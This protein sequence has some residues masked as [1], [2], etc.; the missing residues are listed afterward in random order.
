[1]QDKEK[2]PKTKTFKKTNFGSK[3][4]FSKVE[5]RNI[6]I[7]ILYKQFQSIDD[8]LTTI[9]DKT[10][11]NL[12]KFIKDFI[13]SDLTTKSR[14]KTNATK[15]F[16]KS[17]LT[18]SVKSPNAYSSTIVK[19]SQNK[20]NKK[21]LKNSKDSKIFQNHNAT[22]YDVNSNI[23]TTNYINTNNISINSHKFYE[24]TPNRMTS[25]N[26]HKKI[27]YNKCSKLNFNSS[28]KKN[29]K[30]LPVNALHKKLMFHRTIKSNYNPEQRLITN[31]N[32]NNFSNNKNKTKNRLFIDKQIINSNINNNIININNNCI[33]VNK[34]FLSTQKIDQ[35]KNLFSSFIGED[36]MYGYMSKKFINAQNNWMKNYFANFI[37]KIFRGYIFRKKSKI[38]KNYKK[39]DSPSNIIDIVINDSINKF[40]NQKDIIYVK[41]RVIGN[42]S[43]SPGM[44]KHRRKKCPTEANFFD[45]I[46]RRSF[47]EI[48]TMNSI[49][50]TGNNA[51]FII[52]QRSNN[53]IISSQEVPKIKEIIITKNINRNMSNNAMRYRYAG[54]ENIE[55][56]YNTN[57][58]DLRKSFNDDIIRKINLNL[59]ITL[60]KIDRDDYYKLKRIFIFWR[61]S[62]YKKIII[63]GLKGKKSSKN[64]KKK[65]KSS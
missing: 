19:N 52:K 9:R 8:T 30:K 63:N 7:K 20:T 57:D 31:T 10:N 38:S 25:S 56:N 21:I 40:D 12:N 14:K 28:D 11:L 61:D 46:H 51:N 49:N 5:V 41:K 33:N 4:R 15:K 35:N 26:L 34:S 53:S 65:K 62:I 18:K 29:D 6:F 37:Q 48:N 13:I 60:K 50:N 54:E 44:I 47:E 45:D 42:H 27:F 55:N 64:L 36:N 39:F 22:I 43:F 3:S 1:M 24:N 23:S 17:K 2:T 58:L 59:G 32:I 16:T